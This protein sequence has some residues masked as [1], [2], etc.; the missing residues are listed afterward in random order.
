MRKFLLIITLIL[1]LPLVS[2]G[3][4]FEDTFNR[5]NNAVV[6]NGWSESESGGTFKIESNTLELIT[7]SPAVSRMHQNVTNLTEFTATWNMT[8]NAMAQSWKIYFNTV[9]G[10]TDIGFYFIHDK[11]FDTVQI[12]AQNSTTSVYESR[13]GWGSDINNGETWNFKLAK[14]STHLVSKHWDASTSEPAEWNMSIYIEN[15]SMEYNTFTRI[16]I[17]NGA[18]S[19]ID[20]NLDNFKIENTFPSHDL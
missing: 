5:A 7:S 6:G 16:Q 14:N 17:G 10:T 19:G 8:Y 15:L 2:A 13:N 20:I 12:T 3:T 18:T 4:E 9:N 1:F 11:N